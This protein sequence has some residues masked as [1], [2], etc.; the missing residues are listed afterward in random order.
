MKFSQPVTFWDV[1]K[2][3]A[4]RK[5]LQ[6][7]TL[8]TYYNHGKDE[9]WDRQGRAFVVRAEAEHDWYDC[10]RPYYNL[11]PAVETMLVDVSLDIPMRM[12]KMP[13]TAIAISFAEKGIEQR[14]GNLMTITAYFRKAEHRGKLVREL[15]VI[16]SSSVEFNGAEPDEDGRLT[17]SFNMVLD[18]YDH[19]ADEAMQ[20]LMD[21]SKSV[22]EADLVSPSLDNEQAAMRFSLKMVLGVSMLAQS[23]GFIQAIPLSKDLV[24]WNEGDEETRKRLIEKAVKRRGGQK[25][26][27][28]GKE[29]EEQV[30]R[31]EMSPHFRRPHL[32][33]FWTGKGRST[34]I[35]KLRA[36]AVV[37]PRKM[38]EVPTGYLDRETV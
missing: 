32:A 15:T 3:N 28:V 26:F 37:K 12:V 36:G 27:S 2:R 30:Q 21:R 31:G 33:T 20:A 19:T 35:M 23:P 29:L 34:P 17:G 9:Y 10:G 8:D 24:K 1:M 5:T 11:Y 13:E 4:S 18:Y 16:Y 14:P 38:T 22:H 6:A 7:Y 25:A